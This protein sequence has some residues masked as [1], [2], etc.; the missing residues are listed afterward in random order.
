MCECGDDDG[1]VHPLVKATGDDGADA[2][3]AYETDGERAA[4]HGV[5]GE[6]AAVA[7]LEG[8]AGLLELEADGVGTFAEALHDV[9]L[10]AN[11]IELACRCAFGSGEEEDACGDADFEGHGGTAAEC[12]FAQGRAYLPSFVGTEAKEDEGFFLCCDGF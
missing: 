10:A 7:L 6:G 1:V 4:V 12:V 8:F 11:P 9:A 5:M 2:A 3:G